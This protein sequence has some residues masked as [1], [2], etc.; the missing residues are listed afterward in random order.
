MKQDNLP[1]ILVLGTGGTVTGTAPNEVST[2]RY[3]AGRLA[4]IDLLAGVP[5]LLQYAQLQVETLASIDSKDM[6]F[7]LWMQLAERITYAQHD[8]RVDG[9]VV[10]HGS[11]TL[12]ETAYFLEL[13]L[14]LAKPLV[15]VGAMRPSTALSADGPL[16]LLHAVRLAATPQAQGQGPLVV[17]NQQIF[18]AREV[19]KVSAYAIDAFVSP[20]QGPLARVLDERIYW[21]RRRYDI[22]SVPP[23]VVH[24]TD[25]PVDQPW[26]WV[27]IL[28][29][30]V[31]ADARAL[32]ALCQSG[33]NGIVLA[34][35]G[36]GTLSA[37]V[38][39][40]VDAA[41]KAGVAVVRASRC[42]L[43]PVLHDIGND[44][45]Q[46]GMLAAGD[47]S[48]Q[49]ARVLLLI[50]LRKGLDQEGLTRLFDQHALLAHLP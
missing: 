35:T 9:V 10:L 6:H 30:G 25:V 11:D 20:G 17:I 8:Q 5:A 38:L 3:E 23:A 31:G 42:L 19:T 44:D 49:K 28:T 4:L 12:E 39:A 1:K 26:P 32:Q 22:P 24:L 46:L 15:L 33:V 27:E 34:G 16:N 13:V 18:A 29:H 21:L 40:G 36:L 43:G 7:P 45:T 41:R 37:T 14:S 47:L 2:A 48:P 50:G